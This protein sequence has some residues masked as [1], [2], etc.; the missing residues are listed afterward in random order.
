MLPSATRG[1]PPSKERFS[2]CSQ[3]D[4]GRILAPMV[5]GEGTR[6]N[7]LLGE[8]PALLRSHRDARECCTATC[9]LCASL[10]GALRNG[11]GVSV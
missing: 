2:P 9:A 7:C 5:A 3:E 4:I 8:Y 11:E 10:K 6:E 1:T